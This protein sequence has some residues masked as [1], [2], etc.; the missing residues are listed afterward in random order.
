MKVTKYFGGHSAL[1]KNLKFKNSLPQNA[2]EIVHSIYCAVRNAGYSF[3]M[4]MKPEL[5][6]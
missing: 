1:S 3:E 5:V 6:Y 4:E 2:D